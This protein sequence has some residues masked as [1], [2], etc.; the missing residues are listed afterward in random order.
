MAG[1]HFAQLASPTYGLGSASNWV[2]SAV[3]P[4]L[5]QCAATG[6]GFVAFLEENAAQE[7]SR[8]AVGTTVEDRL[9]QWTGP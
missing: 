3:R 7:P 5:F 2:V 4:G 9:Q 8:L 6:T 1:W